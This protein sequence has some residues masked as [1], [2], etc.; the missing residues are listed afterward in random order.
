MLEKIEIFTKL[1]EIYKSSEMDLFFFKELDDFAISKNINK[2]CLYLEYLESAKEILKCK[3]ISNN[4]PLSIYEETIKDLDYKR[5][6][7]LS[8][9]KV[10][11]IVP[12]DWYILLFNVHIFTFD[13]L[14]FEIRKSKKEVI[15]GNNKINIGDRIIHVHIPKDG[16]RLDYDRVKNSYKKAAR[17]F[18]RYF[19][20][21]SPIPFVCE[22]WLLSK[23]TLEFVSSD[24]N[25][26]KFSKDYQIYEYGS[27]KNNSEAFRLFD[28][29]VDN[30]YNELPSNSSLRRKY[31]NYFKN[32]GLFGYGEGVYFYYF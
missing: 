9:Y 32:G 17:F 11:G 15:S 25:I 12:I 24:S 7:C 28:M 27:D 23:Q 18:N 22:S 29:K 8:V 3:Y 4:I 26:Y 20:F 2:Y 13:R 14:Q 1:N 19:N 31:I 16:T 30:N 5:S 21:N 6:E 10:N